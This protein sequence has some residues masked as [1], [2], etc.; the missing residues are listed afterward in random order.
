MMRD[1][2][3]LLFK[4]YLNEILVIATYEFHIVTILLL[5]FLVG[6]LRHIFYALELWWCNHVRIIRFILLESILEP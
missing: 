2:F 5:K 4:N 1:E 6:L 3:F